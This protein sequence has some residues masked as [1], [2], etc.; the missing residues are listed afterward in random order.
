MKMTADDH[1]QDI[2]HPRVLG[3]RLGVTKAMKMTV[4]DHQQDINDPRVLGTRLGGTKAMK[5][6]KDEMTTMT[7]T[8]VKETIARVQECGIAM[9]SDQL[10]KMIKEIWGEDGKDKKYKDEGAG[11]SGMVKGAGAGL[12]GTVKGAGRGQGTR[13]ID[14]SYSY[15]LI[16]SRLEEAHNKGTVVQ[17]TGADRSQVQPLDVMVHPLYFQHLR[18]DGK[19]GDRN[20]NGDRNR[21]DRFKDADRIKEWPGTRK[22]EK[23]RNIR[24]IPG[25]VP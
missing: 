17:N 13:D 10:Q 19:E 8:K 7:D 20:K 15:P 21:G 18:G 3:T 24:H 5:M 23:T 14:A 16:D 6:T 25:L 12:G 4:D 22:G 1:Q 11:L 2:N 9:T